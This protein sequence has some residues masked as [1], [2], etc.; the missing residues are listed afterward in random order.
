MRKLFLAM[1][2]LALSLSAATIE[3]VPSVQ[4]Q[5]E[6][7]VGCIGG[8]I[9]RVIGGANRRERRSARRANAC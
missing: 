5:S 8:R 6:T 7:Q 9:L 2:V 3:V 4:S 1:L